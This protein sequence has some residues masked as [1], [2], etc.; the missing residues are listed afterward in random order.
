MACAACGQADQ[1]LDH[2]HGL[3]GA[4][5]VAG[6]R[7]FQHVGEGSR[8]DDV[9]APAGG[10]LALQQ[11]DLEVELGQAA[12]L[13]QEFFGKDRDVGLVQAGRGEDVRHFECKVVENAARGAAMAQLKARGYADK[14]RRLGR[15]IRLVAVEF[16]KET[17]NLAAF[18]VAQEL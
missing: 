11:L 12:H 8:L 17:R 2:L 16:S 14:P 15:P 9:L 7:L 3:E 1:F 18:E 4:V 13:G 10:Q 6:E 5:P